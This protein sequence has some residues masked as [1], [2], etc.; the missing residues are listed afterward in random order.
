MNLSSSYVAKLISHLSLE[1]REEEIKKKGWWQFWRRGSYGYQFNRPALGYA[2]KFSWPSCWHRE[3]KS[4]APA[5]PF[6]FEISS[7]TLSKA[8]SKM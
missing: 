6:P 3:A 5:H 8:L 2:N 7:M 4:L 1:A